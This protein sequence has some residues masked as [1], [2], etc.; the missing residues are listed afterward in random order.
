MTTTLAIECEDDVAESVALALGDATQSEVV[1][2][3]KSNL[4]GSPETVLQIVQVA[5][6]FA[7]AVVPLISTYLDR[8]RIK[9]IKVGDIEIENPTRDQWEQLWEDHLSSR[10]QPK[11]EPN[12]D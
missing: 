8:K 10:G 2:A 6:S 4:D 5:T 11:R 3:R 12:S 1:S 9:K 7:A